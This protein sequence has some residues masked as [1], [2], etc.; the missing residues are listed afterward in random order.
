MKQRE[1]MMSQPGSYV[2]LQVMLNPRIQREV[3]ERRSQKDVRD[4]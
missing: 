1:T 3:S 4:T 2:M